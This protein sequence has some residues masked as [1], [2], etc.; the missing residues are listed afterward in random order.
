MHLVSW[1]GFVKAST[2]IEAMVVQ[3]MVKFEI[4]R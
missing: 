1:K 3:G 4:D 2:S